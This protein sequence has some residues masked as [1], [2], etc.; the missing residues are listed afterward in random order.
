MSQNLE[1]FEPGKPCLR[2][3]LQMVKALFQ[4]SELLYWLVVSNIFYFSHHIGNSNPNWLVF[5]KMVETTNQIIIC[6]DNIPWQNGRKSKEHNDDVCVFFRCQWWKKMMEWKTLFSDT[7]HKKG[8]EIKD[9][10]WDFCSGPTE[11]NA[12]SDFWASDFWGWAHFSSGNHRKTIG[13]WDF[14]GFVA[15]L[16]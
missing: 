8:T 4:L 10:P 13:N 9:L 7:P 14:M 11:I 12:S 5:F 2:M 3:A 1:E 15:D 16:W 6:P